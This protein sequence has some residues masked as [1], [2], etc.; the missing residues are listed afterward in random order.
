MFWQLVRQFVPSRLARDLLVKNGTNPRIVVKCVGRNREG[1]RVR[2][3]LPKI[4]STSPTEAADEV[5]RRFGLVAR[6]KFTPLDPP[7][8]LCADQDETDTSAESAESAE[9]ESE[10]DLTSGE[11]LSADE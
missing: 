7:E 4:R 11:G 10:S 1:L 2:L 3:W 8:V 6:N 9:G 5:P